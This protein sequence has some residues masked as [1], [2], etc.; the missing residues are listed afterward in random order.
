MLLRL[1][2]PTGGLFFTESRPLTTKY[3]DATFSSCGVKVET[4]QVLIK[5]E[6][7]VRIMCG[8]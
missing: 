2:A 8:F 4:L 1:T 6:N 3:L 7:S 5:I